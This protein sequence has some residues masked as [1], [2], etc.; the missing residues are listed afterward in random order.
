MPT[1]PTYPLIQ[2]SS[3]SGGFCVPPNTTDYEYV[4]GSD[5]WASP[6][7]ATNVRVYEFSPHL[8]TRGVRFKYEAI[9]P[10]G[11]IPASEVL[12][13]VP[14]Y[15]FHWQ[16]TYR[17][18]TPKDLPA[19]TSIRCTAGWDNSFQNYE[20]MELYN[21]PNNPNASLYSPYYVNYPACGGIVF[22]DQT[23]DE[24]FIGYFNYTVLP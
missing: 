21:D 10:A 9:Y 5:Q 11:H 4:T 14:H 18:T 6:P 8:H 16:S 13:S 2:T 12:L 15:V 20:L 19:G 22:G 3:Y 23:W 17:L 1:A 24:M 7:F